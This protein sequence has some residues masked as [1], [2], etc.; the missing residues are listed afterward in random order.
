[1]PRLSDPL[2]D[3]AD[4]GTYLNDVN[5]DP[6]RAALLIGQAQ[7]LCETI[8]DPLPDAAAAV[9]MRVAGRA[10]QSV[11]S[12]RQLAAM[13]A[14]GQFTAAPGGG[15]YLTRYDIADLRRT[16]GSGGAFSIDLLPAGYVAPTYPPYY[17]W[18]QV[19]S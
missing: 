6:D 16:S 1:M 11:L 15:V 7:T 2:I 3:P 4:L 14:A 12:P 19:G 9:V 17:D 13:V 10:Y 18:D 5:L 8:I